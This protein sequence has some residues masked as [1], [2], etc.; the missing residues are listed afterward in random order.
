MLAFAAAHPAAA[1]KVSWPQTNHDGA[2]TGYN[3]DETTI[4][5]ANVPTL[6]MVWSQSIPGEVTSFVLNHKSL[7]F[8]GGTPSVLTAVTA[9]TGA[10][11]WSV[12]SGN[13]NGGNASMASDKTAIYAGCSQPDT[14]SGTDGAICAYDPKTGTVLWHYCVCDSGGDAFVAEPLTYDKGVL[15][16][17]YGHRVNGVLGLEEYVVAL[18]A[19]SGTEIWSRDFGSTNGAGALGASPIVADEKN[20]YFSCAVTSTEAALC[21][22]SK[23]NGDLAWHYDLNDLGSGGLDDIGLAASNKIVY[24]NI[25]GAAAQIA[26]LN[27]VTGKVNWTIPETGVC[28]G[29]APPA[30]TGTDLYVPFKDPQ[31]GLTPTIIA[32]S[33]KKGKQE[34]KADSGA[35]CSSPS[36]ANGVVYEKNCGGSNTVTVSAFDATTGT[37]LWSNPD[38][39]AGHY[40][41]PIVADGTLYVA[42]IATGLGFNIAAFRPPKK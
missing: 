21:A 22:L 20:V 17:G 35:A 39:A 11:R 38:G 7:Y 29:A 12:T 8:Q 5:A 25:N 18:D 34:W 28:C 31:N 30:V 37:F 6:Q 4:S 26:A 15:Y 32:L 23:A 2:R 27:A 24:A 13:D 14:V 36:V 16:L 33:A 41:P 19:R 3:P 40:P 9:S 42:N 1:K 10:I